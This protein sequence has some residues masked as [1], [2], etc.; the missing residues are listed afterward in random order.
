MKSLNLVILYLHEWF[1]NNRL[2]LHIDNTQFLPYKD[3]I[4]LIV[5]KLIQLKYA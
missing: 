5:Y 2:I 3:D 1:T 4:L